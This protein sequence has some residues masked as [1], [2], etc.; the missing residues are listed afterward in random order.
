MVNHID[1]VKVRLH[2]S[3]PLKM[4]ARP[5]CQLFASD[6]EGSTSRAILV[7]TFGT[8]FCFSFLY[9]DLVAAFILA[10]IITTLAIVIRERLICNQRRLDEEI[11]N[12]EA[13]VAATIEE[14]QDIPLNFG[15]LVVRT[16]E[17]QEELPICE[18]CLEAM[19]EGETVASAPNKECVHSFHNDCIIQ[20]LER[21]PTCPCCRREYL[22]I[23]EDD[24][25]K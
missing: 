20:A 9:L 13:H 14:P 12:I 11:L 3:Y 17:K 19:E 1:L 6:F 4:S 16:M 21:Q 5:T 24:E 15:A 25:S 7:L 2:Q 23:T 18:I 10:A 8:C 22:K